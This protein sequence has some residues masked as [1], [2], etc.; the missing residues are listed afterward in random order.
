MRFGSAFRPTQESLPPPGANLVLQ[1]P[2]GL[3]VNIHPL[4][5]LEFLLRGATV[6]PDQLAIAHPDVKHPVFYSYSVWA[7]RVQNFAYALIENGVRPGDRVAVIAPNSYGVIGARAIIVSV[8]IRLTKKEV[9]Y[10][11]EHSGAKLVLVDHEFVHLT[12]DVRAR[13]IVCEDTGR[14]ED[15]YEQFLSSGRRFSRE[16]GWLGLEMDA[17]ETKPNCLNY[18]SGTTGRPKGVLTTLRGTY[19]AAV[20]NAYEAR[21]GPDSTYL[22][23]LPMFHAGGWTYP[24]ASTFAFATQLIIRTVNFP[25]IW[26]HFLHSGVTH[27]CGAPTVQIGIVNDNNARKLSKPIKAII[28]GAA[29]TAH[30]LGALEK[31]GILPFH[32]YGL[33]ETYGP[34]VRNYPQSAW[35]SLSIEERAKF[36]AR[37]GHAFATSAPVRVVVPG[38]S[39]PLVDVPKDG[40]TVG[41]IAMRGNILMEGYYN[42]PEATARAFE[43]GYF[44]TGDLAVW[45]PDG[46]ISIQD[47]SKDLII[48][49]GENAST[50]AIELELS[51]HPDVME[52]SVVGRPHPKW[53]ER[54][55]AWVILHQTA[56]DRWNGRRVEFENELIK[57]AR[58]RLPGFATPEWVVVVEELPKT[59]TGKIV[60]TVL[61][62]RAREI[63]AKL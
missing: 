29:P 38:G 45:Y 46:S 44:H 5:P 33:T 26:K 3:P 12:K 21:M 28:A 50:L 49:G 62:Q 4:N 34:F 56:A 37:Q 22:W 47:R 15:P 11:L 19:L 20:A 59:S 10:I 14:P 53:G 43:G 52:V 63:K 16:R 41:E 6:Y 9:D 48:S 2:P 23:V 27:Y 61:R 36:F 31:L 55:M 35:S 58:Q 24:W 17:D 1:V 18:T 39:G 8:N 54:P 57:Y 32:V 7:Q 13:V 51:S 30:T 60:K 42:D 25:T 40:K